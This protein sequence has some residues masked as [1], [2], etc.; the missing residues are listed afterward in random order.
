MSALEDYTKRV[1]KKA[2]VDF[3]L[4][5]GKN[6]AEAFKGYI[7]GRNINLFALTMH[8]RGLLE[9]LFNPSLTRKMLSDAD[10]PLLIFPE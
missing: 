6:A 2:K 3:E 8:K 4:I 5:K 10:I 9:R 7:T 1:V